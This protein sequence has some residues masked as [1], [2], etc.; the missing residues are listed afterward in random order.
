LEDLE[1]TCKHR[2]AITSE[3]HPQPLSHRILDKFLLIF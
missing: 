1:A 3:M 2:L